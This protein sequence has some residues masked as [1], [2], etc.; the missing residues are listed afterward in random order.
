MSNSYFRD[1]VDRSELQAGAMSCWRVKA[2]RISP[3]KR[4]RSG[5]GLM[6][7]Q[8]RPVV[9]SPQQLVLGEALCKEW[10]AFCA[11]GGG[12]GDCGDDPAVGSNDFEGTY[13][14]T[15]TFHRW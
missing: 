9:G 5:D 12:D 6:D 2:A 1:G 15:S 7:R 8:G 13:R 3:S 10:A 11:C 4:K 14:L